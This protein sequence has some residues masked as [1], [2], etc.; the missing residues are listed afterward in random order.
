MNLFDYADQ[1]PHTAGFRRAG[2][3]QEAAASMTPHLGPP[4]DEGAA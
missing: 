1:Y 3:S 2:A 4:T